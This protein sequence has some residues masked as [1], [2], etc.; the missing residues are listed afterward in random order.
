[1]SNDHYAEIEQLSDEFVIKH[2]GREIARSSAVKALHE[3]HPKMKMKPVYYFPP[4]SVD[5]DL[6]NKTNHHTRCP[7]KGKAHYW[8]V[9]LPGTE[10][11]NAV[12]AYPAGDTLDDSKEVEGY[13]AFDKSQG[14]ELYRNGEPVL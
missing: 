8:T 2:N 3:T 11:E 6:L 13:F 14:L 4:D 7:I 9:K 10:L 12:W 1:M 5:T